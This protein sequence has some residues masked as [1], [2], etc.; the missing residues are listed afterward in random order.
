MLTFF[1]CYVSFQ[2]CYD[3]LNLKFCVEIARRNQAGALQSQTPVNA[4]IHLDVPFQ[5]IIDRV[6]GKLIL[7]FVSM[8]GR[9]I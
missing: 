7:L 9:S 5:T 1:S 8:I 6:K 3:D 2:K 4:V